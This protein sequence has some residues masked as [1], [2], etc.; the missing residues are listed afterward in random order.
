MKSKKIIVLKYLGTNHRASHH[1][2]GEDYVALDSNS[3]GYPYAV[4]LDRAHDFG[5]AQ[6]AI[7][8][9]GRDHSFEIVSVTVTYAEETISIANE[10]KAAVEFFVKN[11]A[12]ALAAYHATIKKGA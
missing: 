5:T 3:G 9:A 10:E 6:K 4:T 1:K 7:E 2:G 8:Y 12:A 11:P